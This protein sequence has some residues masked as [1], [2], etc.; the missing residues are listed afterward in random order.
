MHTRASLER[1]GAE[2]LIP[3]GL[4]MA[5]FRETGPLVTGLLF[6][7]RVGAGIGA[8]L[9]AMRVTEQIDALESLAVDSFKYLV[10]TRVAA[11]VM[12]LPLLTTVMNF[13]GIVGGFVA[14]TAIS[15]MSFDL[16]FD[17][18]FSIVNFVDYVPSTFKTA[19]FGFIIG[20]IASW[21]GYNTKGGSAGVGQA[22]TRS[23]VIASIS[24]IA[25]NV[26]LVKLIFFIFPGAG[27]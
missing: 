9:G 13:T 4:A 16:Y 15:G 21:L 18:A 6:A 22:S 12:V 23:V 7:G 26:L 19:V 10:V 25:S 3:A 1:F 8:E 20:V 24:V 27:E 11:C 5:L 14:E 2:A 17:R